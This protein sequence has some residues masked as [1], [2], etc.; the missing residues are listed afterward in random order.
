VNGGLGIRHRQAAGDG[1]AD[2]SRS[3]L[4]VERSVYMRWAMKSPIPPR[5]WYPPP[6]MLFGM[7]LGFA[8]TGGVL[9][10][11]GHPAAIAGA[12]LAM[13]ALGLRLSCL[14]SGPPTTLDRAS[15]LTESLVDSIHEAKA[16][17]C[18]RPT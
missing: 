13:S 6:W 3:D 8:A 10:F 12:F 9:A 2:H 1:I 7:A 11:T 18:P 4:G 17:P 5:D 14:R 15:D 16:P